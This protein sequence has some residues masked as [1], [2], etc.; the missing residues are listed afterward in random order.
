MKKV[1][2][3]LALIA[4][5]T[6]CDKNDNMIDENLLPELDL[7]STTESVV[8]TEA[9]LDDVA[10]AA[11]YEVEL[12]TGSD[13]AVTGLFS[14]QTEYELKSGSGP[15]HHRYRERYKLN[16]CP[17]VQI[18]YGEEG[19]PRTITLDYG[20]ST[21]LANGRII[22]G[23]I[24]IVQTAPR[25]ENGATCTITFIDFSVDGVSIEG[26]IVKT[27]L[28]DEQKVVIT[29]DLTFTLEDGTVIERDCECTR[30]WVEGMG[31][32]LNHLDDVFEITGS[33]SCEDSDGNMYQRQIRNR[34]VKRGD[35]RYIVAGEVAFMK[36]GVE[37]AK[38][39]YGNGTCDNQ[40]WMNSAEGGHRFTIG[41]C[42]RER[43][44][45]NNQN[46]KGQ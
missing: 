36:N 41:N 24:Q 9:K 5:M 22:S 44:Q 6:A 13:E 8:T 46:H 27:F 26:I 21:E 29:R 33:M 20:E 28:I 18:D 19:W 42:V 34:L 12:F 16:Q 32:A 3:A 40:A 37:F 17:D 45:V 23:I 31:T 35:C 30:V 11:A 14:N 43:R 38:I 25:T 15:N 1:L 2:F 39:N 10:E 7:K 4:G